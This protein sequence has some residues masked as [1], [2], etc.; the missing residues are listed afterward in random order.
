M[1][2]IC[3][4]QALLISL[5]A[6]AALCC[7]GCRS[8]QE[9]ETAASCTHRF[10]TGVTCE[11]A[12]CTAC[13][14]RLEQAHDYVVRSDSRT[15][16][17]PGM[18]VEECSVCG[19]TA[20][21]SGTVDPAEL[22]LP[23][24]Y[25]TDP[26]DCTVP[27]AQLQKEDGEI[28][29]SVRYVSWR[30]PSDS[31]SCTGS[32]KVQGAS[33]AGHPKKNY[34]VKL[35]TDDTLTVKY[36]VDLGWGRESKYC[37]KANYVDASQARNVCAARLFSQL[38]QARKSAESPLLN[39]PNFGLIDGYPILVYV[40]GSFHGLYTMNIP[41]DDWM[42][43]MEGGEA[44]REAVLQADA[45][46]PSVLLQSPIE[47][48][49]G[50]NGW[51]LEHCSTAD[52]AWVRESFNELIELLN[53][54]DEQRIRQELPKHLDIEAA[55]DVML[56]VYFLNA[57]D[58]TAKNLLWATYDGVKW[59]P[60]MYDMDGSFG[61]WHNGQPIG[62]PNGT[63]ATYNISPSVNADGSPSVGDSRMFRTVA[64]LYADELETRYHELRQSILTVE[65]TQAVFDDFLSGI[66]EVAYR[67]DLARWPHV[68][69]PHENRT[70]MVPSTQEQLARLDAFFRA[71]NE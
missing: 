22:G 63:A 38:V 48:P 39:A 25:L 53:C 36:K 68:P 49:Y 45:W 40:N 18:R 29:V 62:N 47:G 42:F 70:N 3:L 17:T 28:P 71:F 66:P 54:K 34:N 2:R 14:A 19:D 50:E 52:D 4:L 64:T 9:T 1:K 44:S 33:S 10:P 16:L 20:F 37:L 46:T 31:F 60:S 23:T 55:I 5:L 61:M 59:I 11:S 12:E 65:N 26:E 43:A 67:S 51:E 58:N 56:F 30:T 21:R 32:I 24:V 57:A 13:G 35:F 7:L 6:C 15:L 8:E 27:L 41:K 69:Y